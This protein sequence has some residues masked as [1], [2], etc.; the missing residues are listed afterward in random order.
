MATETEEIIKAAASIVARAALGLFVV[1][2]HRWSDRPCA[3]CKQISELIGGP[4]GCY[5]YQRRK[6]ATDQDGQ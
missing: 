6:K 2:Q 5:E 3:T 4:F 1:D